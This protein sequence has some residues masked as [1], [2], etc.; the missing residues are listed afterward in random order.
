[1]LES[2]RL[3]E[4]SAARESSCFTPLQGS[5]G[6]TPPINHLDR[7]LLLRDGFEKTLNEGQTRADPK[8]S[9]GILGL[10]AK[11]LYCVVLGVEVKYSPKEAATRLVLS[12]YK[13]TWL[14]LGST[15]SCCLQGM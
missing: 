1:M 10:P 6:S 2:F 7:N 15:I 14:K 12:M 3:H 4:I 11:E 9:Q 8:T 5:P 13:S